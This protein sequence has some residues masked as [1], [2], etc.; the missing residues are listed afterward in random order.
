MSAGFFLANGFA[1]GMDTLKQW[2]IAVVT[3][4]ILGNGGT[5]AINS[6]YDQDEGDIGYL[7]NPPE[8]PKYLHIVSIILM[9]VGIPLAISL[10]QRFFITYTVCAV[11][12]LL[13]SVPP[14]R[15]KARAG[16]DVV[17]NSIGYG[18]LTFYAGWAA[19]NKPL[20]PTIINVVLGFMFLF[21]GFYPLTQIYQMEEDRERGD[22]TLAVRLDKRNA[23][24]FATGAVVIG[25]IFFVGETAARYLELR[26]LGILFSL[27]LWGIFLIDWY[28][29]YAEA[30][31]AY[32]KRGFYKALWIWAV[33][34]I[35]IV[36]AM[37]PYLL[38]SA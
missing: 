21:A 16:F 26:S 12:S 13:Y 32:E 3:W 36:L 7:D 34:D 27:F 6:Y 25:F 1:F 15:A 17:I 38:S 33:T 11:L 23:L 10:G 8:P 20:E 28:K 4:T 14:F 19:L 5:L 2:L 29:K 22:V 18:G 30:D 37:A 9:L 35:S 24:R 31:I